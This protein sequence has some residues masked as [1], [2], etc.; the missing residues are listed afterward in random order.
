MMRLHGLVQDLMMPRQQGGH[1]IGI[2]LRQS[3]AAFNIGEKKR[4]CT[5][6]ERYSASNLND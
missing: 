3:G 2:F 6:G 4:D 5:G 1:L